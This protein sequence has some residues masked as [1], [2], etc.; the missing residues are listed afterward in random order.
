MNTPYSDTHTHSDT[1]LELPN[2]C[3]GASIWHSLPN[4][5]VFGASRNM[6][7]ELPDAIS[8]LRDLR[9]L[10]LAQNCLKRL[11]SDLAECRTLTQVA[12][13]A[14]HPRTAPAL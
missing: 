8:A 6:L 1:H 2:H 7:V 13:P 9:K 10:V 4:L 11:P 5:Q 12:H 14:Q 3:F